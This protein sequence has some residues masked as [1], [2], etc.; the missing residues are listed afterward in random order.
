MHKRSV[1]RDAHY[2]RSVGRDTDNL[3]TAQGKGWIRLGN[4]GREMSRNPT[5]ARRNKL[6][7]VHNSLLMSVRSTIIL[8]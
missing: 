7:V 4:N 2:G 8:D 3:G 6:A 1:G 5:N